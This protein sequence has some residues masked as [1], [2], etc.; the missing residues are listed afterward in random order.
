MSRVNSI[1]INRQF[2]HVDDYLN[3][4]GRVGL[5]RVT[6]AA[7][8]LVLAGKVERVRRIELPY[9]AWEAAVLPL[10]YTRAGHAHSD[11][12]R[13]R[14]CRASVAITAPGVKASGM[15]YALAR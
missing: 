9:A 11:L 7:A 1:A 5:S 14:H 15:K 2:A 10:N 6:V 12:A 4:D 3:V 8:G 13:T